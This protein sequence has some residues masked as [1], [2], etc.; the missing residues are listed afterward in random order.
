MGGECGGREGR[1]DGIK[2]H[3]AK[4]PTEFIEGAGGVGHRRRGKGSAGWTGCR[5]RFFAL[6]GRFPPLFFI[7][8]N[9]T[10]SPGRSAWL[11]IRLTPFPANF[12]IGHLLFPYFRE[13]KYGYHPQ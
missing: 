12:Q 11:Y 7:P 8:F 13:D 9:L 10:S 6:L 3:V 4:L 1:Q 2:Y 5:F